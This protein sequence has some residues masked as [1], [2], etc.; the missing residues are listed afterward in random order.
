MTK[1]LTEGQ[2]RARAVIRAATRRIIAELDEWRDPDRYVDFTADFHLDCIRYDGQ[3]YAGRPWGTSW[4][5]YV[6]QDSGRSR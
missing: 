6:H 3:L 2:K 4:P 5:I 1:K